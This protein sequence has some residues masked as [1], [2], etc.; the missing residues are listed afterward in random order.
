MPRAG[1]LTILCFI[2]FLSCGS[3][4]EDG[5]K[6]LFEK[7][8]LYQYISVT[9]NTA[10][11]ERYIRNNKRELRQGGIYLDAPDKLLFE[12]SRMAFV[13][14]AFMER[15][16][17]DV[18]F[19]GLGAGSMPKYF[20]K[21]YPDANVDIVEIDPDIVSVAEKYFYFRENKKM[22]VHVSDGRVFVKRSQKK[23]DMIFLDAYQN[24]YIPFHLTTIEF[25]KELKGRLKDDGVVASNILSEYRNKF[26]DS[27]IITY[28]KAFPHVYVFEGQKSRNFIFIAT[29]NN[30]MMAQQSV[31][32]D[33]RKIQRYRRMDIDLTEIAQYYEYST[34][35]ERKTAKILTDDFAP[36][37][38]YKYQRS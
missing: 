14:L 12:Y 11:R 37:N 16:P 32:G 38:L 26:F 1:I 5:E 9:E 30:K 13:S 8:S 3:A 24:D 7:N 31:M 18:L 34:A 4:L 19:V 6:M 29:A 2:L 33:A 20:N 10:K 21:Y 25:L 27:M 23:Y 15:D 22:K 17:K 35:Y 36:V 28:R